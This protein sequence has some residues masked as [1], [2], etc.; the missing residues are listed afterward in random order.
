MTHMPGPVSLAGG[1]D[2]AGAPNAVAAKSARAKRTRAFM[3][4]TLKMRMPHSPKAGLGNCAAVKSN[5]TQIAA[6]AVVTL[7]LPGV[8]LMSHMVTYHFGHDEIQELLGKLRIEFR[9]FGEFAKAADLRRFARG[10]RGRHACRSFQRADLLR[11]LKP[12]RQE[13]DKGR[14]DI[15]DG[16]AK[17]L[18]FE[19]CFVSHGT[20]GVVPLQR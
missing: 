12:L 11:A 2:C 10:I 8:F 1:A 15:V 13:V 14:I 3:G 6:N 18:Q 9:R 7:S 4:D 5:L 20:S 19:C 16:I 17:T